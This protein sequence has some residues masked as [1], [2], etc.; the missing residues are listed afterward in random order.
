MRWFFALLFTLSCDLPS[1]EDVEKATTDAV[2]QCR[3]IFAEQVPE[4]ATQVTASALAA[5]TVLGQAI[6]DS[7]DL[8]VVTRYY[9]VSE[10]LT[11]MGCMQEGEHWNCRVNCK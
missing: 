9:I 6:N 4:I 2:G 1:K 5:C 7:D 3:Q 10:V 11:A 8:V